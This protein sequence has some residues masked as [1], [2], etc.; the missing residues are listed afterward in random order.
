VL[1]CLSARSLQATL[2]AFASDTTA[3][4]AEAEADRLESRL[5]AARREIK[6]LERELA[7]H[8]AARVDATQ[9]VRTTVL[10]TYPGHAQRHW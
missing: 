2:D 9:Q 3:E 1:L 6:D 8:D 4:P 5:V 7:D 10:V